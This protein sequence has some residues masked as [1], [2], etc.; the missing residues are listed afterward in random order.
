MN[1]LARVVIMWITLGG[2]L[3]PC[4]GRG[5]FV[6]GPVGGRSAAVDGA[7][8]A[9]QGDMFFIQGN[10]AGLADVPEPQA[11]L[12]YGRLFKGMDDGSQVSRSFFGWASPMRWGT[13]G[14]SYGGFRNGDIYSEETI[15]LAGA[16][17]M[18]RG[19]AAGCAI[20]QFRKKIESRSGES[21]LDPDTGAV[22]EGESQGSY[23][24]QAWDL[25]AGARWKAT[26]RFSLGVVG[27]NLLESNVGVS[28]RDPLARVWKGGLSYKTKVGTTMVDI[29]QRRTGRGQS[30][31]LHGG[32]ETGWRRYALRCGGG[33]GE[34]DYARFATGIGVR[35]AEFRLDYGYTLSLD[36]AKDNAGTHQASL[37]LEFGGDNQ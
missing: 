28:S 3:Y 2:G 7:L 10:P 18:G 13:V 33:W 8:T 23:S 20:R 30:V 34:N 19:W 12:Y 32:F 27:M 29:S 25:T 5:A 11:G 36:G 9:A 26:S 37:L 35:W 24:A 15:S 14:L 4:L 31:R 16:R 1:R 17:E 6:E 22:L 21:A